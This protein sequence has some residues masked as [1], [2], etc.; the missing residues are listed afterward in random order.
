M[1]DVLEEIWATARRNKLRTALTGFAVAWGIF[2]LI[3]LLGAGNGLINGMTNNNRSF[4]SN[5]MMVGGGMTSKAYKGLREGRSI[6]LNDRDM[7]T[8]SDRFSQHVE[9]VG[10][11]IQ[12][13]GI[14]IS[15]GE[16]YVSSTVN[17]VYPNE[18]EIN[19]LDMVAGRFINEIDNELR[20]KVLVISENQAKE[21]E[22]KSP[23]S[24]VGKYVKVGN[25]AFQVVGINSSD[26]SG[27]STDTYTA[28]NTLRTM[29]GRGDKADRIVFSFHGLETQQD[30]DNFEKQ[31]KANI[32]ANHSAAPD[33]EDAVWIWNRF[34]QAMQM[35]QGVSIIR[36]ALWIVG[37][38]T[39]LSGIVGVSNIML[40]SVKERTREFGIRKAIGAKPWGILRLL[41]IESVIITT[42]FGYIG[43]LLGIA[44]NQYMDATLGHQTVDVGVGRAITTFLDPTVGL[45]VCV[46]ATV[47]MIIAGTLA[48]FV[49]AR[50]AANV[51]PIEALRAE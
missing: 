29:Y 44:A 32:N 41:I 36:T 12:Q 10:G 25:F 40:I 33:D 1:R 45:D 30:N 31:Y 51:Q 39:L 42:F 15:N 37:I 22:P 6:E 14:T 4:M 43:M 16:N 11:E 48:G 7:N 13:G 5:S 34:T 27:M 50:R 49:P 3:F 35:D 2:M 17:G 20:R 24:L 23:L 9:T 46:E 28:F 8:T 18:D 47:L 26:N 38:F 19:K 21:L